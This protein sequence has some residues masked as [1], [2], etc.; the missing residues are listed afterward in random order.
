MKVAIVENVF[1]LNIF[2]MRSSLPGAGFDCAAHGNGREGAYSHGCKICIW[3]Q[4]KVGKW[5][6]NFFLILNTKCGL[7]CSENNLLQENLVQ[8]EKNKS[9]FVNLSPLNSVLLQIKLLFC[10]QVFVGQMCCAGK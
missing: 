8:K 3:C 6:L 9:G 1:N 10:K 4:G 7:N 5:A 2:K